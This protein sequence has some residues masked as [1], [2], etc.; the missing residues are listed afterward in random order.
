MFTGKGLVRYGDGALALT[1]QSGS[2]ETRGAGWMGGGGDGGTA[3]AQIKVG[4]Y[5]V[6]AAVAG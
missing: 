5:P 3:V 4:A 6:A 1:E 2:S